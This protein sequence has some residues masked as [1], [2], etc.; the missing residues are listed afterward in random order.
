DQIIVRLSSESHP[1]FQAHFPKYPILPGFAL[2]DIL[3]KVLNDD[4]VNIIH[5]KFIANILP[6]DVLVC[7]IKSD[8]KIRN[9]KIF[10][11]DKKVS[12]IT[13]ESN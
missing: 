11:E 8:H 12:E 2:I 3:A 13:Y 1:V 6:N 9:I 4:V 7:N 5:S 10:K